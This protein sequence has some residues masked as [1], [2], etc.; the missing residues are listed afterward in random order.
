VTIRPD[1]PTFTTVHGTLSGGPSPDAII[2][3][4]S[5]TP[6]WSPRIADEFLWKTSA[7]SGWLATYT[8]G[9]AAVLIEDV[10]NR[11]GSVTSLVKSREV[12]GASVPSEQNMPEMLATIQSAFGLTVTGLAAVLRVERPTIYAW[13]KQTSAPS[14]A[15]ALRARKVFGLAQLWLQASEGRQWGDLDRPIVEGK[16]LNSLLRDEH[17]RTFVIETALSRIARAAAEEPSASKPSLREMARRR[18]IQTEAAGE[19][20]V[21]TGRRLGPED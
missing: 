12:T 14:P 7:F 21:L 16:T 10:C 2:A 11:S 6:H 8:A 1:G 19:V 18:G 4:T 20:D 5:A 17:L 15:N 13:L 3:I 9:N